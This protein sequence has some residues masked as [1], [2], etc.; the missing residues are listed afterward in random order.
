MMPVIVV[1]PLKWSRSPLQTFLLLLSAVAGLSILLNLS[2]NGITRQMGEP[3]ASLWG[4][5]LFLGATI[6]I[7]GT[8]WKNRITGMLI[9]R[10]GIFLL[11][12]AALIWALLVL[13]YVGWDTAAS[14][15]A[16]TGLFS[17][18][19]FRQVRYIN[20]HISLIIQAL[21]D[22]RENSDE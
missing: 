10:A 22:H 13:F 5:A 19:C 8:Y 14:S 4:A 9:E 7:I 11:G 18:M 20:Y 6:A 2:R 1:T 17:V 3:Y 16:I 15:S 21:Q 12:G